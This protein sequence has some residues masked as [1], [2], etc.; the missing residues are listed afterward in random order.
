[1][2]TNH[3]SKS[4]GY[5][6]LQAMQGLTLGLLLLQGFSPVSAEDDRQTQTNHRQI[7]M[8]LPKAPAV[9]VSRAGV[10]TPVIKTVKTNAV[11]KS[12]PPEPQAEFASRVH[13]QKQA[14][15]GQIP[16]GVR[17]VLIDGAA[18]AERLSRGYNRQIADLIVWLAN[19]MMNQS[20]TISPMHNM[21]LRDK[22]VIPQ[23]PPR[24]ESGSF[25]ID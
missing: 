3:N 21:N 2:F 15:P 19:S 12:A 13:S 1:M 6:R 9:T 8:V 24:G 10:Q 7:A 11:S 5:A 20:G 16:A 17:E 14:Q 22:H 18:R 23:A 25:Q 4:R